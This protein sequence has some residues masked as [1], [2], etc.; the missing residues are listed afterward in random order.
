MSA[1][2]IGT[3]HKVVGS[4]DLLAVVIGPQKYMYMRRTL[5][6]DRRGGRVI[7]GVEV[8]VPRGKATKS[9][10][11]K[12]QLNPA[13]ED[14]TEVIGVA[15]GT[16]PFVLDRFQIAELLRVRRSNSLCIS[17]PQDPS[18]MTLWHYTR[19]LQDTFGVSEFFTG[20]LGYLMDYLLSDK[21]GDADEGKF[22]FRLTF[23]DVYSEKFLNTV[24]E[25]AENLAKRIKAEKTK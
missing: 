13:V 2:E 21:A 22:A 16:I 20:R 14:E 9:S 6:D 1:N 5:P 25:W 10:P 24:I 17:T 12:K 23:S 3:V 18:T 4:K 19:H 7:L 11:A 8:V 15:E